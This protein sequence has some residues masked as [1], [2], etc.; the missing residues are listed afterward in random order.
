MQEA[1]ERSIRRQALFWAGLSLFFV[2][3]LWLLGNLLL[4][5]VAGMALAYLLDPLADFLEGVGLSRLVATVIIL[6]AFVLLFVISLLIV[7]PIL[8]GQITGLLER[9][10]DL[11]RLLRQ[12]LT[13]L[14]I[15]WMSRF[16]GGETAL[17]ESHIG[18]LVKQG[19][20]WLGT[21][22]SG[23]WASGQALLSILSL[24]VVTPVVAF[25]L[26]L[27]WDR[28]VAQIDR[29]LPR[30]HRA[31]IHTI[32]VDI[33]R[34]IAGFVRG[35]GTLCLVLGIFYGVS[36]TVAGLNFGLLIGLFAGFV[37]FIPYVGSIS[38]LVLS[39]G[40]ALVQYWPEWTPVVV[41]ASIFFVGQFL[42]GNLLQPKLVG[43]QV[44]LHP[45]WVMF[46]LVV[47]GASFGFTGMLVAVPAAAAIAVVVRFALAKYVESEL[48]GGEEAVLRKNT[49]ATVTRVE[50]PAA[51]GSD[52][53][54]DEP[55]S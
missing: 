27:D 48:Y 47:F 40:V 39:V 6:V 11:V 21:V 42:E 10:P 43:E 19:A 33:D 44:G 1:L 51:T 9:L 22:L 53:F 49:P 29:L 14:D 28:M 24:L 36:L 4:P 17:I 46:A 20:G 35:Q 8:G 34:V 38:G 31:T 54:A 5:F 30:D 52:R 50:S 41:I 16:I 3:F 18:D 7:V 32:L 12:L 26:L 23:V 37:S 25:Y 45:V 55:E 13:S 15:E 2:L